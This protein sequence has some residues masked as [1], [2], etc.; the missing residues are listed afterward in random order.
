[1][2]KTRA[3]RIAALALCL[4]C[5]GDAALA[6]RPVPKTIQGCVVGGAF[7]SSNG[8]RIRVRDTA[9]APVDLTPYEDME[10]RYFGHLLPGDI[11]YVREAPAVLGPCPRVPPYPRKGE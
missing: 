6:S 10:I 2:T 9:H 8:Y 3:G 4:A 5:F 1:M 11:Y 7:I